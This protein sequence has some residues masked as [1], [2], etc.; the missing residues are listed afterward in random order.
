MTQPDSN[1]QLPP[2]ENGE[3]QINTSDEI[4]QSQASTDKS[5]TLENENVLKVKEKV[6]GIDAV[7]LQNVSILNKQSCHVDFK[8]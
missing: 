3:V 4:N 1:N 7:K 2:K 6:E 8:G 5:L